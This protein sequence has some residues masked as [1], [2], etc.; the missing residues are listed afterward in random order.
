M[1]IVSSGTRSY[2]LVEEMVL[3]IQCKDTPKYALFAR[4]SE[5]VL[6]NRNID[7]LLVIVVISLYSSEVKRVRAR[8]Y[9]CGRKVFSANQFGQARPNMVS[10]IHRTIAGIIQNISDSLPS[11]VSTQLCMRVRCSFLTR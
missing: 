4:D 1:W 6:V 10:I 11:A 8:E 9:Y 5:D 3:I 7:S 2:L